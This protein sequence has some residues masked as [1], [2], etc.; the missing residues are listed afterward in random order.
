M[1]NDKAKSAL[2]FYVQLYCFYGAMPCAPGMYASWDIG[3]VWLVVEGGRDW[4]V[5]ERVHV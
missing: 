1:L 4:R 3:A 2:L 5:R